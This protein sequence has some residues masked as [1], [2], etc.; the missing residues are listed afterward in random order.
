MLFVA[1]NCGEE[2]NIALA[3]WF[4]F[5]EAACKRYENLKR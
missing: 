4:P 2:L 3:E 5:G 1:F